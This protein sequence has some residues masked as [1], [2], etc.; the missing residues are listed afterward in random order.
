MEVIKTSYSVYRLQ[1][2]MVIVV[3]PK[4]SIASV[5]GRLKSQSASEL[6]RAF[7]WLKKVYWK[8][9]LVCSQG[10][11]VSSVGVDEKRSRDMSN[12]KD[13]RIQVSYAWSCS[14]KDPG[15]ARGNL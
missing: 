4:Y 15:L 2:H 8:E 11:F 14:G 12:F 3:P 6:R 7:A 1:Y 5:M 13:T 10:Y 9:N